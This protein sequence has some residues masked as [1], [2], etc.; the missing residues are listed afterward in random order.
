M[1]VFPEGT[2]GPGKLSRDRYQLRRF[3]RGGFVETAMRAGVPVVPIAVVGAEESMPILFKLSRLS[4]RALGRPVPPGHRQPP[5]ARARCWGP[6]LHLPAKFRFRVLDPISFDVEPEL[7][8]YPRSKVME[9]ADAIRRE[10]QEELYDML[11]KRA[12]VWFG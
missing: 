4:G 1:L 8:R 7:E 5:P 11:A 12:S 3:G 9:E 10:L 2:K 6:S